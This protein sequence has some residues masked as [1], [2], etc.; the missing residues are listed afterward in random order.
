M[1]GEATDRSDETMASGKFCTIAVR[2]KRLVSTAESVDLQR[3]P[4]MVD[5]GAGDMP[6]PCTT[7]TP[8]L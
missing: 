2:G 8:R 1:T 6:R 5:V 7:G 4:Q 3:G